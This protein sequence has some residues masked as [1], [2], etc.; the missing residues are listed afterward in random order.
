[1]EGKGSTHHE[2]E[3]DAQVREAFH[4]RVHHRVDEGEAGIQVRA[5]H[6]QVVL[7]SL[8]DVHMQVEVLQDG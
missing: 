5:L 2:E 6:K 4:R 7:D 1:M 8:V 3:E